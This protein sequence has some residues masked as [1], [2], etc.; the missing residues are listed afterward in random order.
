[1][2]LLYIGRCLLRIYLGAPGV[3][4]EV[5]YAGDAIIVLV[6]CHV[7]QAWCY[8]RRE[9][10]RYPLNLRYEVGRYLRPAWVTLSEVPRKTA[11]L[12]ATLLRIRA[13]CDSRQP[14]CPCVLRTPNDST[15][16]V[17]S[18]NSCTVDLLAHIHTCPG[19][20]KEHPEHQ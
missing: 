10:L 17:A 8:C 11:T 6:F 1:M 14:P 19:S 18:Q 9:N 3:P 7:V 12:C 2:G 16:A 4:R 5:L 15:E 13:V 20:S